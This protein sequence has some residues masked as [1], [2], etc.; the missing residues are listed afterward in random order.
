MSG[1]TVRLPWGAEK[2][3]G[4]ILNPNDFG[5]HS[6]NNNSTF[7]HIRIDQ[8]MKP[9]EYTLHILLTQ[10]F[11]AAESKIVD[12]CSDS[13]QTLPL[14]QCLKRGDDL[15]FDQLL[16]V[17]RAISEHSLPSIVRILFEWFRLHL[18][19][20]QIK[21][22]TAKALT[23][24]NDWLDERRQLTVHFIFCLVLIDVLKQLPFHPGFDVTNVEDQAF[25]WFKMTDKFND[26]TSNQPNHVNYQIICDLYAEVVGVLAHSRFLTTKRRFMLE[27]NSLRKETASPIINTNIIS[28]LMGMRFFRVKMTP[29]E[30]FEASFQ[31]LQ[32]LA[33]YFLEIRERDIKNALASLFVEI[34]LPVA[35]VVKLEVN[36]P[37]VRNFVELLHSPVFDLCSKTKHRLAMFPLMTCLLCVSQRQTFLTNWNKF[38]MLCLGNLRGDTKLARVALESLYRLIW[39]YMVRIKGENVKTTNQHLNLIVNSL[40]PKSSKALTPKDGPLHIFVKIIHFISKEKLDFA[41]K[42]I[43]FDLLSVGRCRNLLP[44][45]MNVGLRAFLVI[46]DSLAQNDDAPPMPLP[47]MTFPSGHTIRSRRPQTKMISESIVKEIGLS[48]YYVSIRKTFDTILKMLDTQVG[49]CLLLT[50]PDNANKDTEDLLSGDRKPKLELLRTCIAAIPRLLPLGTSQ[51]ELIEMLAR[52][53]IH[54]DSELAIQAFQSL[55]YFVMELPDWRKSVFRGF[56]NFIIREV[57]DTLMFLSDACKTTLENSMKFL[58]QLVQ[59]WKYAVLN[60]ANKNGANIRTDSL[61]ADVETLAMVEGF[62]IICLSQTQ[63]IRRKYGVLLLREIKNIAVATKCLQ[64]NLFCGST[65]DLAWLVDRSLMWD[66]VEDNKTTCDNNNV[67]QN[68]TLQSTPSLSTISSGPTLINSLS[69]PVPSLATTQQQQQT[70]GLSSSMPSSLLQSSLNALASTNTPTLTTVTSTSNTSTVA[71]GSSTTNQNLSNSMNSNDVTRF[72]LWAECLA[73]LFSYKNILQFPYARA[74]AWHMASYRLNYLFSYV[75]PNNQTTDVRSSFVFRTTDLLKKANE[76]EYNLNLWKNYLIV[77]C[78]LTI[79]GTERLQGYNAD[80]SVYQETHQDS[81]KFYTASSVT[82]VALFRVV[83]PLVRNELSDMREIIIRGLGRTNPEA[84]KDLFEDLTVYIKD[85]MEIKQEKVR[86]MKKRDYTRLRLIRIF[87]LLADRDVFRYCY[88]DETVFKRSSYQTYNEYLQGALIYLDLENEKDSELIQ[89]IRQYFARF[90]Y[91]FINQ[92]PRT[93]RETLIPPH[94]RYSL[95]ELFRKWSGNFNIMTVFGATREQ[96][97]E[98]CSELELVSIQAC[99]ATLCC[100]TIAFEWFQKTVV[101]WLDQFIAAHE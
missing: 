3:H 61:S 93:A 48:T 51:E 96:K 41:M 36:I 37:I 74:E 10:F 52:L 66:A 79:S 25:R 85:A 100:G 23:R 86:R 53:T 72:D 70:S 56:T 42:D 83:V 31:F 58:L 60:L 44:E 22:K 99:A 1:T 7:D 98:P 59:Q 90:T 11:V 24:E 16:D 89:Q 68:S 54:M 91:K 12:V 2:E 9:G 43:I 65:V 71:G 49:R 73:E 80:A 92:I 21:I 77:A 40:F 64:A 46:A 84:F 26:M 6:Y 14:N 34:L 76:R 30:D 38:M 19:D 50:R 13:K 5:Q 78:C 39:V 47:S 29:V 97:T 17:L 15:Q 67:N 88:L 18:N 28:L 32:D 82:A 4:T 69:I 45:R 33:N 95:F 101:P 20:E 81:S 75:D 27:L 35:A 87:E 63:H 55:Q 8:T 94:I 62:G 57:T